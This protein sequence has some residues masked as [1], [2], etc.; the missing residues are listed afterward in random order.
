MLHVRVIAPTEAFDAAYAV[1]RD[2]PGVAHVAVLRGAARE[3]A[4]DLLL[5]DVAREAAS[6]L[7]TQLR[8]LGIEHTGGVTVSEV[9]AALSDAARRAERD[10]PGSSADAVVWEEVE[11]RTSEE[12]TLSASFVAFLVIAT[13]IAA[14]GIV[15]DNPILIVGAMVVGPEFGPL[16]AL[17]V[18]LVQRR[19]SFALRSLTALA[20]SF[21]AAIAITYGAALLAQAA[22]FVTPAM[23]D[24]ER[25][26]TSFIARPDWFSFF[27]AFVAGVAGMLSL[28]AAKS[29]AL[30]GVLVSVTTVPA[31]GNIALAVAFADGQ[32][33]RGSAIQLGVNLGTIVAA[34]AVTLQVQRWMFQARNGRAPD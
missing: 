14:I 12:A 1:L 18:A 22:G 24:A 27:V 4:G 20:V 33:A 34:G 6:E 11:T 15:H 3:P 19:R 23:L 28:T 9:D 21:P 26:L 31:A 16:A 29:G 5:C 7:L 8:Q 13:L 17:C 30:V 2:T 25:P 32:Q 10:A